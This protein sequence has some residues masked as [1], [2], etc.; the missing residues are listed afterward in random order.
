MDEREVAFDSFC[1]GQYPRLVGALGLYTGDAGVGEELAQEAL[2]RAWRRWNDVVR[3]RDPA[4][5]LFVVGFN[6]AKSR[7]RRLQAERRALR[8]VATREAGD[9]ADVAAAHEVRRAL[10]ALPHRFRCVLVLR[11]YLGYT[12]VETAEH[13][14][15]PVSTVKTWSARGLQRLRNEAPFTPPEAVDAS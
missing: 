2:A 1:R 10:A 5:W 14:G 4:A 11:Y 7:V 8:R 12:V 3:A 9:H 15:V 13:L 6:L